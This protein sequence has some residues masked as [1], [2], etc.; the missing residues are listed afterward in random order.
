MARNKCGAK[1]VR[2]HD[3]DPVS[4]IVQEGPKLIDAAREAREQS[5][6]ERVKVGVLAVATSPS[7]RVGSYTAWNQNKHRKEN[8]TKYC[9][10]KRARAALLA[11]GFTT[12]EALIVVGDIQPDEQ[13]HIESPYLCPCGNC[14]GHFSDSPSTIVIPVRPDEDTFGIYDFSRLNKMYSPKRKREPTFTYYEDPGFEGWQEAAHEYNPNLLRAVID[15]RGRLEAVRETI[16]RY[17]T[18][19][20][21]QYVPNEMAAA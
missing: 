7:G 13:T 17:V 4:L 16:T 9:G 1:E 15:R 2:L 8:I 12:V 3:K 14:R 10:E 19:Q 11:A 20:H 18:S 21:V 5:G 6:H